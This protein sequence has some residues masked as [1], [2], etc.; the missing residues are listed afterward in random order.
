MTE[1]EQK[2]RDLKLR[3][4][5]AE[6]AHPNAETATAIAETPHPPLVVAATVLGQVSPILTAPTLSD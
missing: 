6:I 3:R 2:E 5:D 4:I 1:T